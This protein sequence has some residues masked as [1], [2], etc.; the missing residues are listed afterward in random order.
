MPAVGS[1]VP[2]AH[3]LFLHGKDHPSGASAV[4]VR[5]PD[6]DRDKIFFL[7]VWQ[8]GSRDPAGGGYTDPVGETHGPLDR[9]GMSHQDAALG[10]VEFACSQ[11]GLYVSGTNVSVMAGWEDVIG[12]GKN[13]IPA[14]SPDGAQLEAASQ[15][16][17]VLD[18]MA[19]Y[20][21]ENYF[22]SWVARDPFL[23]RDKPV[24]ESSRSPRSAR[25]G[26][27][28]SGGGNTPGRVFQ[29]ATNTIRNVGGALRDTFSPSHTPG[30]DGH[31]PREQPAQPQG[32]VNPNNVNV[33][34][35][36][37]RVAA[38]S[39]PPVNQPQHQFASPQLLLGGGQQPPQPSGQVF[40]INSHLGAVPTGARAASSYPRTTDLTK[41]ET[42]YGSLDHQSLRAHVAAAHA[43]LDSRFE[44]ALGTEGLN[45]GSSSQCLPVQ[46]VEKLCKQIGNAMQERRNEAVAR[47][48]APSRPQVPRPG[49]QQNT[50]AGAPA[51][52]SSSTAPPPAQ[53][54]TGNDTGSGARGLFRRISQEL[55]SDVANNNITGENTGGGASGG[56][57]SGPDSGRAR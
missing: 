11:T 14:D 24:R 8:W 31:S 53:A 41:I 9:R 54:Q 28:G 27:A 3:Q 1:G 34:D 29:A 18:C 12:I 6:K 19:W 23:L 35:D 42:F 36:A 32:L 26:G 38:L 57:A 2:V 20:G 22:Q 10:L 39:T 46:C 4:G 44:T 15:C 50:G 33:M 16:V 21:D 52:S 5:F 55:R 48:N 30:R 49:R 25:S 17:C 37:A 56:G 40:N 7:K 43:E 45:S 13:S 51:A 47:A